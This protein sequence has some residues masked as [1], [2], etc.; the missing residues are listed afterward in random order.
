MNSY[1][2][3]L[4]QDNVCITPIMK[5]LSGNKIDLKIKKKRNFI[6]LKFLSGNKIDF[7]IKKN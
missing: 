5:F 2:E 6:I 3:L 4:I 1:S 7:K